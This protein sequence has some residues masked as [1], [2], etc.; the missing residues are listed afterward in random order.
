MGIAFVGFT[1]NDPQKAIYN[2]DGALVPQPA[3]DFIKQEPVEI[4]AARIIRMIEKRDNQKTFT[5]LGKL[6][7]WV[8]RFSRG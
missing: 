2:K 7:G 1:E 8:N 6:N 3:R 5:G 4:V